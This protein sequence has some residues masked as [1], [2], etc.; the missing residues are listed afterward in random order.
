M[1]EQLPIELECFLMNM[2]IFDKKDMPDF[3]PYRFKERKTGIV[4]VSTTPERIRDRRDTGHAPI[5]IAEPKEDLTKVS[6]GWKPSFD[7]EQP[8]F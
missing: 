4:F 1:T 8:P 5:H 6:K 2:G 3:H 7:G